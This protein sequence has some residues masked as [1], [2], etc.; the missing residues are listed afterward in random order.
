MQCFKRLLFAEESA[1]VSEKESTLLKADMADTTKQFLVARKTTLRFV[2]AVNLFSLAFLLA[3]QIIETRALA[4]L[5][6]VAYELELVIWC[7]DLWFLLLSLAK[8]GLLFFSQYRWNEYKRSST[9]LLYCSVLILILPVFTLYFPFKHIGQLNDNPTIQKIITELVMPRFTALLVPIA[10][11]MQSFVRI[12]RTLLEFFGKVSELQYIAIIVTGV[13]VLMLHGIVGVVYQIFD[14]WMFIV[15]SMTF[16]LSV[17]AAMAKAFRKEFISKSLWITLS[18]C[19]KGGL[20][21]ATISLGIICDRYGF[22][23]TQTSLES[24]AAYMLSTVMYK[25]MFVRLLYAIKCPSGSMPGTDIFI[26]FG[27]DTSLIRD[28]SINM[29]SAV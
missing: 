24:L 22:S 27:I 3:L 5:K 7:V 8:V 6:G 13:Y 19:E 9:L 12:S 10:L 26:S 14:D 21:V 23:L 2:L 29:V 18:I 28:E 1:I 4:K 17:V 25:D 16:T 20:V 11:L 15:F